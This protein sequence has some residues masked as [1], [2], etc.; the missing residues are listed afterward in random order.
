MKKFQIKTGRE[1][2]EQEKDTWAGIKGSGLKKVCYQ[3]PNEMYRKLRATALD[4]STDN[5]RVYIKDIVIMALNKY[6]SEM[7]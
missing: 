2:T 6:F 4:Q 5:H 7:L 1:K 3:I